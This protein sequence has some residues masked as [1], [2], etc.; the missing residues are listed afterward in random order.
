MKKQIN[1]MYNKMTTRD[2]RCTKKHVK[3]TLKGKIYAKGGIL[4]AG[5]S[6]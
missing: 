6:D 2:L 5:S 3:L 4:D 1:E